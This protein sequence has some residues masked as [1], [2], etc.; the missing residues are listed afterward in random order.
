MAVAPTQPAR[1][2][3]PTIV[4]ETKG[5]VS[6]GMANEGGEGSGFVLHF[7][8]RGTNGGGGPIGLAKSEPRRAGS[9][10]W[11][12]LLISPHSST[13]FFYNLQPLSPTP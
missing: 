6:E 11:E 12:S 9:P 13:I 7:G 10:G 3:D 8:R 1:M 4:I 2:A 5:V